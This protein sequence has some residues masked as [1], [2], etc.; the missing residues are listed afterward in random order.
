MRKEL[1]EDFYMYLLHG[2]DFG[3]GDTVYYVTGEDGEYRI[4]KTKVRKKTVQSKEGRRFAPDTYTYQ[5]ENGYLFSTM[6]CPQAVFGSMSEAVAYI[7]CQLESD[8]DW[9]EISFR[10]ARQKLDRLRRIVKVYRNQLE[11]MMA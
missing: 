10:N 5:C 3:E 6:D 4:R 2:R 8:I 7:V 1:P 9:A 11:R